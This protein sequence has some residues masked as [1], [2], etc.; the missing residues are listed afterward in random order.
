MEML[1]APDGHVC[2]ETGGMQEN[3]FNQSL[4]SAEKQIST[5]VEIP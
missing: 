3:R 2:V 1:C 4:T 5:Q